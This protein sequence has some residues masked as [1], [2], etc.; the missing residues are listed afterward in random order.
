MEGVVESK[1]TVELGQCMET[2]FLVVTSRNMAHVFTGPAFERFRQV[3]VK[4]LD[5]DQQKQIIRKRLSPIGERVAQLVSQKYNVQSAASVVGVGVPEMY[6]GIRGA[7]KLS[8]GKT[9]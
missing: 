9:R 7:T 6:S 3:K 5:P 2:M 8:K 4:P 1:L